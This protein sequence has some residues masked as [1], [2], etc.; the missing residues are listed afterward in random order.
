MRT[1]MTL[2]AGFLAAFGLAGTLSA[3]TVTAPGSN[4][5][6][7]TLNPNGTFT[8]VA[9]TGTYDSVE[10]VGYNVFNNSAS[11]TLPGLSLTGS[12]I[13]GFDQDGIRGYVD[14]SGNP[15]FGPTTFGT[16]RTSPPD[17]NGYAGEAGNFFST[18][19]L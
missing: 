12:G 13:A 19:I 1:M 5:G 6:S 7:V 2:A 11:S 10:D 9:P 3:A 15:L 18:P 17:P 14:G 16:I 8:V 4:F